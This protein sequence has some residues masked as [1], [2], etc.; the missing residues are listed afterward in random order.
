[1]RLEQPE[2]DM[3]FL[4]SA[5][6]RKSGSIED[7]ED[8][9]QEVLLAAL[10]H[11]GEIANRKAWL[12]AVLSH[13]Y[14]D[15]LR[16]KYKLPTVSI[17]LMPEEAEPADD[18]ADSDRPDAAAVRRE[19]AHLAEKYREVIVRH[20]L[21]GEKVQQIAEQMGLPRGTVLS[22]LAAGREQMK[23]GLDVMDAYEKHSYQPERLDVSC[24]GRE[25][26][27]GEPWSLVADDMM[28]QN[29][30][31]AAYEKP[32]TCVEIARGL[33]IPTAYIERAVRDLL[34]SQLMAQ[35][36]T[37]VFTDFL[38]T[39]P[40]Q[41]LRVLDGQ[42]AFAQRHYTAIWNCIR[43]AEAA[44][45]RLGWYSAMPAAWQRKCAYYFLLHVF[46]TALYTAVRRL[47]PAEENFPDRPGGGRWI[48]QGSRY[49][50]DFDFAQ[51][52]FRHYTY[53][54]ERR[55]E[56]EACLGEKSICLHVYDTQPD[57]NR[58]EQG[59]VP[60]RDDKLCMLLYLVYKGISID[61]VGFEP[62]YLRAIPHL[63]ACGVF[64]YENGKARVDIPVISKAAYQEMDRLRIDAMNRLAEVL[65]EPLRRALPEMKLPVPAHLRSRVAAFRQ[66][67][68][69][70]I[71][72]AVIREAVEKGDFPE[73][74]WQSRP[75]MVLVIEPSDRVSR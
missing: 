10:R 17:D 48:A 11:P 28:K 64:R 21:Y 67:S 14:Y 63:A 68:C 23:K 16:Q 26:L 66:Y 36:G 71:P 43:E 22:R 29:I 18:P 32:L 75:P 2:N 69:Y 6:L 52:R 40:E 4:F 51:Y 44:L 55:S 45:E 74:A 12:S 62:A 31:I 35:T 47:V 72:M 19:V 41:M 65:T 3:E 50:Q 34:S 70:A 42:I 27:H 61:A 33:G 60:I 73:E 30:L 49:P 8:L 59:P 1:M 13:K 56:Y 39:S 38:I 25:G 57:L 58:Y 53:G 37:R 54:G 20:Y 5:A 7:A 9:T 46:S 24:N 15:L